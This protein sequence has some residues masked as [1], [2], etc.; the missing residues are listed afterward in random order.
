[1]VVSLISIFFVIIAFLSLR[2]D[3]QLVGFYKS[4]GSYGRIYSYLL[5]VCLVA[6]VVFPIV[7]FSGMF[8]KEDKGAMI[9][10]MSAKQTVTTQKR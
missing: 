2:K 5:L 10:G 9:F 1:M 6:V 3:R 7:I 4:I 8:G